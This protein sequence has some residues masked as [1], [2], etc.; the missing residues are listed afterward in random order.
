MRRFIPGQRWISDTETEQG[1]GTVLSLNGRMVTLL[2]PATT[3]M[4]VY[5]IDNAPLS[6]VQFERDDKVESHE[7]W[8]M[9]VTDVIDNEGLLTYKGILENGQSKVLTESCLSNFI[10]FNKPQDKLLAGQIDQNNHYSIRYKTLRHN[11][12]LLKSSTRGL[13][14]PRTSLLPHQL[15]I[16]REVAQRHAPRV[17]LADEVGMGKTI[18]A[19]MILHQQLVSGRASRILIVVPESLLHQ[20]LVEM[21]RRF[22]LSFSLFDQ[23][24]YQ[25][26][27]EDNPF[28]SEQLIL[29]SLDFICN[30]AKRRQ[31]VLAADWDLMVVDEA[32]H[33]VWSAEEPSLQYQCIEQLAAHIPGLLLL[34]ATPEQMGVESHFARLRLLDPNRF[35][36]LAAFQMAERSYEPVANA[37]RTLL[38]SAQLTKQAQQ[39]LIDFLGESCQPLLDQIEQGQPEHSQAAQHQL[40]RQ[41]IDRHGTGRIL[42]RNTRAS[43]GGFPGRVVQGY[44]QDLPELYHIALT[45]EL[46]IQRNPQHNLY[47]ELSYQQH[48]RVDDMDPWWKVDPRIDWLIHLIKLLKKE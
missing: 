15:H 13:I 21:L 32:H 1:L 36:D 39:H 37:V 31:Q 43:V 45:E 19:G 11:E 23:E 22:N 46:S 12:R 16:A 10:R 24:R 20:W 33:L 40:L 18:E 5:S 4:R 29:C 41:L 47:P 17:M 25:C 6:R 8:V 48:I 3:E 44:P 7:G 35:H 34:T 9:T 30:N 42:F 26:I 14:G 28:D 2:F 38:E 27:N